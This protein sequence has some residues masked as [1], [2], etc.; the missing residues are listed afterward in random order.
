MTTEQLYRK[1]EHADE[2]ADLDLTDASQDEIIEATYSAWFEA[3]KEYGENVVAILDDLEP[4]YREAC[5]IISPFK[6]RICGEFRTGQVDWKCEGDAN[7]LV[8]TYLAALLNETKLERLI[9]EKRNDCFIIP[10][11]RFHKPNLINYIDEKHRQI[12]FYEKKMV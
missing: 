7:L 6:D 2:M 5:R 3:T 1:A 10:L 12:I 4:L 8:G 11:Q 9:V